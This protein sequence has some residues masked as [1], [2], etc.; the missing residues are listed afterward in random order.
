MEVI[1]ST[2]LSAK[3]YKQVI[4][5]TKK[6]YY[7]KLA[8]TLRKTKSD[9]PKQYWDIINKSSKNQN[10][11][12]N[13]HVSL[14]DFFCHFK[15]LNQNVNI[16]IDSFDPRT[17]D[18]SINTFINDDI[19]LDEVLT[20]RNKLKNKKACGT[21]NIINEFIKYCPDRVLAIFCKLCG[22]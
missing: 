14:H 9:N 13:C 10:G 6:E 19:S 21:D 1:E 15:N 20:A 17:V 8:D 11:A 12:N 16:N 3:K 7:K 18:H 5:K 22:S 4:K 2:P